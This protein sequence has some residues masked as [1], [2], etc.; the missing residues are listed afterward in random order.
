MKFFYFLPLQTNAV[1]IPK[2][3]D[4]ESVITNETDTESVKETNGNGRTDSINDT[5]METHEIN[6]DETETMKIDEKT[7]TKDIPITQPECDYKNKIAN[8]DVV[9]VVANDIIKG[10]KDSKPLTEVDEVMKT[11]E[12]LPMEVADEKPSDKKET[13][14]IEMEVTP[15]VAEIIIPKPKADA[16]EVDQ[17]AKIVEIAAD[18]DAKVVTEPALV[19][20]SIPEIASDEQQTDKKEEEL[21]VKVPSEEPTDVSLKQNGDHTDAK[22]EKENELKIEEAKPKTEIDN[23]QNNVTVDSE[24]NDKNQQKDVEVEKVVESDE[25]VAA[26]ENGAKEKIEETDNKENIPVEIKEKENIIEIPI[27]I[28]GDIQAAQ[29]PSI[30]SAT[31]G[32]G[33]ASKDDLLEVVAAATNSNKEKMSRI[34]LIIEEKNNDNGQVTETTTHIVK[35]FTIV[36][37]NLC[38]SVEN[39][40]ILPENV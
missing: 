3:S 37:N 4:D 28:D 36:K 35:E 5:K 40:E 30:V 17:S 31:N 7:E 20:E 14:D 10:E 12:P 15:I 38:E 13:E 25:K 34:E 22:V 1:K 16:A 33:V 11:N 23:K 26:S 29:K 19:T 18:V 24:S 2:L 32:N 27:H 21:P 6:G 8:L 9:D 39:A